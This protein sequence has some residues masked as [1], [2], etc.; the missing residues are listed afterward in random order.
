M[1]EIKAGEPFGMDVSML[2]EIDWNLAL[3]RISHDQRTDFIYAPHLGYIYSK[4]GNELID[5][6][7]TDL[8]SGRYTSSLPLTIEVPKP[9]RIQ[10][11]G[12][13]RR[14]GPSFS[15]PGSI[16]LPHDRL[17]YQ[18]LADRAAPIVATKTDSARSFSHQLAD[19]NSASMFLPT[20]LC[21]SALQRALAEHA[22]SDKSNY[23]L[24]L[25]VANFFGSLNLH[26]LTNVLNDSG[27]PGALCKRL[28]AILT[29]YAGQRN[30][31]GILQGI[32]PSDLFGNYYLA[33]IDRFFEECDVPSARYVDDL[34]VFVESVE[35][36]DQLLHKLIPK[37]R[38]YDLV[39]NEN[40][41]RLMPKSA[42]RTEE[43]DLEALF[44]GAVEEMSKQ[45]G[46]DN[47]DADYGF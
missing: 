15:R 14:L 1:A 30:S 28:E 5:N 37:L 27:F 9:F 25:D 46:Y 33:P 13:S 8:R 16:L 12:P 24:K 7:E 41:S 22:K 32:Y 47:F 6:T 29:N 20:R 39:L 42:L 2:S 26:T 17:L 45:I 44:A 3:K 43:P 40:K 21:W 31:R 23:I 35:A 4:A 18:A 38:D 36:A 34:Y 10:I 11:T 19:P